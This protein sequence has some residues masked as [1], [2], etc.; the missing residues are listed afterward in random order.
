MLGGARSLVEKFIDLNESSEEIVIKLVTLSWR[1]QTP[2]KVVNK[3]I[4]WR[5]KNAGSGSLAFCQAIFLAAGLRNKSVSI[6]SL[7]A[8][9][10]DLITNFS[11][12]PVLFYTEWLL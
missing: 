4:S 6:P 3:D 12:N 10:P 1:T 2:F 9:K 11:M 8:L 5:C 7:D